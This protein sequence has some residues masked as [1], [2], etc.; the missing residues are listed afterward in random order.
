VSRDRG[1]GLRFGV[2]MLNDPLTV[3]NDNPNTG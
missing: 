3:G 2:E 1:K